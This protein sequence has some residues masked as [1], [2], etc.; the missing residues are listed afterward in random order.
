MTKETKQILK[1]LIVINIVTIFVVWFMGSIFPDHLSINPD[2]IIGML[3]GNILVLL[4]N[5]NDLTSWA[6]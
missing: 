5:I 6:D 4:K 1:K 2:T 3:I